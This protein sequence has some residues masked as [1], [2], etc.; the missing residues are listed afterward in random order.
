MK[1]IIKVLDDHIQKQ[2]ERIALLEWERDEL[3]K[4][5]DAATAKLARGE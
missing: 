4:A 1:N 3:Q 2:N 5:L